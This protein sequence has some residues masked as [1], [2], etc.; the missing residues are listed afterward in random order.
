MIHKFTSLIAFILGLAMLANGL[1]MSI[2]PHGWYLAVPGVAERGPFNQHFLR[3]IGFIYLLGSAA[4]IHGAFSTRCR[5][6]LWL[7]P[8]AWLLL[9]ALFHIWEVLM[10]VTQPQALQQDFMGVILPALVAVG[11]VVASFRVEQR[12][13]WSDS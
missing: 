6:Q 5:W 8:T 10:G 3:D 2:D 11:L 13:G 4:F 12:Q 9:H 7:L 1:Y